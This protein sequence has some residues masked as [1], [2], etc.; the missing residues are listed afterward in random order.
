MSKKYFKVMRGFGQD[1]FIPIDESELASALFAHYKGKVAFLNRGSINGAHISAIM[2]DY[3]RAL[4][5]NSNYR[6]MPDDWVDLD[7]KG[8]R[9]A[10][11]DCLLEA[12]QLVEMVEKTGR[13]ELL[14]EGL[15]QIGDGN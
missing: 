4:G 9:T 7:R 10:Y 12:K 3:A 1:D 11:E 2:P 8:L 13:V 6:M 14:K 5:Y 15:K